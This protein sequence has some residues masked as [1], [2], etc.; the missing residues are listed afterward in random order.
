MTITNNVND[1]ELTLLQLQPFNGLF[2]RT[3][4]VSRYQKVKPIWILLEQKTVSGSGISWAICKSAPRSRQITTP[5][6]HHSV[7]YRPDALPVAQPT[8]S[9]HW[10]INNKLTLQYKYILLIYSTTSDD[11]TGIFY[12]NIIH[13]SPWNQLFYQHLGLFTYWAAMTEV[14]QKRDLPQLWECLESADE[15]TCHLCIETALLQYAECQAIVPTPTA[16]YMSHATTGK[17]TRSSA[18]TEWPRNASCQ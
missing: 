6:P 15:T 11:F 1:N 7:F 3:T 10:R 12:T 4:W 13:F 18:I 2:S 9:K 14:E 16:F 17:V 8:A 5:V